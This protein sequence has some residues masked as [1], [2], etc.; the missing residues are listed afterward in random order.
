MDTL[1]IRISNIQLEDELIGL[2]VEK[3]LNKGAEL[4]FHYKTSGSL[5]DIQKGV[6]GLDSY[7]YEVKNKG[8]IIYEK[9]HISGKYVSNIRFLGFNPTSAAYI[10]VELEKIANASPKK[11][12]E[13]VESQG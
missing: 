5:K 3:T 6:T 1:K 11:L 13:I 10:K 7:I 4:K 12:K 2:A 8:V 9:F